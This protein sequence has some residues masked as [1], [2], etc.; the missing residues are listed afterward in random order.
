MPEVLVCPRFWCARG[1]SVSWSGVLLSAVPLSAVPEFLVCL[2]FWCFQGSGVPEVQGLL[3]VEAAVVGCC[4][5]VFA[6]RGRTAAHKHSNVSARSNDC[7]KGDNTSL[8]GLVAH[9]HRCKGM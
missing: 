5:W 2:S 7:A 3:P 9:K 4:A 8:C 6:C 1:Y